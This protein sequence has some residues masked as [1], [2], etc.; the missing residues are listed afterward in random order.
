MICNDFFI[1]IVNDFSLIAND[2]YDYNQLFPPWLV[3]VFFLSLHILITYFVFYVEFE[4]TS[5][6]S[7][8]IRLII[9]FFTIE[10][11]IHA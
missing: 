3:H 9:C 5:S 11:A 2:C 4:K 8:Y 7:F 10:K 1:L 6:V